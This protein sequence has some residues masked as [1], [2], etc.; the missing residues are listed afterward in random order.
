VSFRLRVSIASIKYYLMFIALLSLIPR[1]QDGSV[2]QLVIA[3]SIA[4]L[5]LLG[6][7][8]EEWRE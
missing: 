5:P 8:W 4:L 2:Q 7:A 6:A 1:P 3:I